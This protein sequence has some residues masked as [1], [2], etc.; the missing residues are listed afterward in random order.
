MKAKILIALTAGFLT[1]CNV[2][3][4]YSP[5]LDNTTDLDENKIAA[6]SFE[7]NSKAE[8]EMVLT[9]GSE[10]TWKTANFTL[11]N[12]TNLTECRNDD[13]FEF[14]SNGTYT[15][16]GGVTLC[17]AEDSKRIKIGSWRIDFENSK[18]IFDEGTNQEYIAD[19][20]G[21]N[22][23]EIRLKGKYFNLEIRGRYVKE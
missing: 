20:I 10:R 22:S 15:Y 6:V 5:I 13:K 11:S 2:S 21:L 16:D 3:E 17:N 4:S 8:A 19:V 14:N 7:V 18:L 9:N 1:A 23:E 12:S